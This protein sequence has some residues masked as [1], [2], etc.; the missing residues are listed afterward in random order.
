MMRNKPGKGDGKKD[1][2]VTLALEQKAKVGD[3]FI[4]DDIPR[5]CT[6]CPLFQ[7]CMKNLIPHRRYQ[8]IEVNDDV[9]HEC[10]KKLFNGT[11]V[12]IKVKEPPLL[13]S[14]PPKNTFEGININYHSQPC[15]EKSCPYYPNCV[16]DAANSLVDGTTLKVV[17]IV[18][19]IKRE[20]KLG[21]ELCLMEVSRLKDS[22]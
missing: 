10:P 15:P 21:L 12:V 11:M 22:N 1:Y 7:I 20:C 19:N 13:V 4:H 5:A 6:D 3:A 18:K 2:V 16:P 17:K 9:R 8:I 14:F